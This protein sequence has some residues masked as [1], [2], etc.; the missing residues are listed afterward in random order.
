MLPLE[1]G[2]EPLVFHGTYEASKDDLDCVAI[3]DGHHWRLELLPG[4]VNHLRYKLP[5]VLM[6]SPELVKGLH[7]FGFRLMRDVKAL[8]EAEL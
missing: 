6:K 4:V 8:W 5:L 3:F 7:S 1:G 2:Q